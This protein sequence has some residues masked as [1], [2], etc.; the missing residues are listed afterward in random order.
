MK[1]IK[2]FLGIAISLIIAIIGTSIGLSVWANKPRG[3]RIDLET[4]KEY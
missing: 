2:V 4:I 3:I 1:K